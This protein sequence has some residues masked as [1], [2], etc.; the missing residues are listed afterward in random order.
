MLYKS[1]KGRRAR[2]QSQTSLACN[3]NALRLRLDR[4]A[5]H[6]VR[7]LGCSEHTICSSGTLDICNNL[8]AIFVSRLWI[9]Q[10]HAVIDPIKV[11]KCLSRLLD[12]CISATIE[13]GVC[14]R[15]RQPMILVS[16]AKHYIHLLASVLWRLFANEL[17]DAKFQK[18]ALLLHACSSSLE[19]TAA[20][21][22]IHR[23][24]IFLQLAWS[25]RSG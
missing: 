16:A 14:P 11:V 22:D 25:S 6:K 9:W 12:W 10:V 4:T 19:G 13:G 20:S 7:K 15:D 2:Y 8:C 17:I 23:C 18:R 3:S 24:H 1:L 21:N 5:Y